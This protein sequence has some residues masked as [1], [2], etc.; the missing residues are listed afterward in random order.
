MT[1]TEA[2]LL[3]FVVFQQVIIFITLALQR[4]INKTVADVLKLMLEKTE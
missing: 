1:E 3:A 2:F 4:S